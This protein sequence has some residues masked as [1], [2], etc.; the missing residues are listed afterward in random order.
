M[1]IQIFG[2]LPVPD[3]NGVTDLVSDFGGW[4]TMVKQR[5]GVYLRRRRFLHRCRQ[6]VEN[7]KP[8]VI[9][10]VWNDW[11]KLVRELLFLKWELLPGIF[12]EKKVTNKKNSTTDPQP[13]NRPKRWRDMLSSRECQ[14][15]NPER[16]VEEGDPKREGEVIE[17]NPG[18]WDE[19]GMHRESNN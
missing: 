12:S 1:W 8:N 6:A 16:E 7:P 9:Q 4:I 11:S 2:V 15:G 3:Y 19:K 18:K 5:F 13:H 10:S 17:C 14:E